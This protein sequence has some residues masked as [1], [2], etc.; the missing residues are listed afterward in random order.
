MDNKYPAIIAYDISNQKISYKLRK[1]LKA[2]R[3]EGQKSVH[4]CLL[5][6]R[7]ADQLFKELSSLIDP[8][9]DKLLLAWINPYQPIINRGTGNS[10]GFFKK[11]FNIQ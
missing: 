9:T 1:I 6:Q 4:E 8:N 2:W 5:N 3:I 7:Q 11:F 10:M